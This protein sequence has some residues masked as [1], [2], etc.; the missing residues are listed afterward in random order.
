MPEVGPAATRA[1]GGGGR[2]AA[3]LDS[4]ASCWVPFREY[5]GILGRMVSFGHV[6]SL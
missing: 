6:Q 4:F 3:G 2:R 1:G 5:L